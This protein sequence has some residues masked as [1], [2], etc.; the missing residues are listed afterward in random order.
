MWDLLILNPL[1]N[2][3]IWLYGLLGHNIILAILIL[4]IVIRLITFPLTWQQQ[5]SMAHTQELQ[6]KLADLKKKHANDPEALN[7]ATMELY[8]KEGI[9]PLGGCLPMLIQFP[10][11]IGLYQ[12]ITRS[13]AASPVQLLDL[14]QHIYPTLPGFL[15]WLP[16]AQALIPL[17][18]HFFWLNLA[19]PDPYFILPAL[20]VISTFLQNKLMTPASNANA[21]P[22]QAAMSRQ[23]QLMM[24]LFIGYMSLQFPSGLSI[25]WIVSNLVGFWHG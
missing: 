9:N 22:N 5:K 21:D 8:R 18:S 23:M 11:L 10:I 4:T 6:P 17:N 16:D 20:V 12:A 13:L 24:P 15:S 19:K 7:A 2:S 3:M 1:V 25:Y 14:S